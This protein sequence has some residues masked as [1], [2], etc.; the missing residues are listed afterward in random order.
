MRINRAPNSL[1]L[2]VIFQLRIFIHIQSEKNAEC[3]CGTI[4]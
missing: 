1:V 3:I 2:Q 4:Q